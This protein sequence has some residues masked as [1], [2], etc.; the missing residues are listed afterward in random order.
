MHQTL[1][2]EKR[3]EATTYKNTSNPAKILQKEL[4]LLIYDQV[5]VKKVTAFF[6]AL[7]MKANSFP[8]SLCFFHEAIRNLTPFAIIII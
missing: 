4:N 5:K 8:E 3:P 1:Q 6:L 7:H 2:S